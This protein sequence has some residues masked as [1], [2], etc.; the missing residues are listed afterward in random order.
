M[1]DL[2]QE[3]MFEYDK[4]VSLCNELQK[5]VNLSFELYKEGEVSWEEHHTLV[6][7]SREAS[8]KAVELMDNMF[9]IR[10]QQKIEKEK[11]ND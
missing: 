3:A 10:D 9:K 6:G 1:T 4:Q 7:V 2:L 8:N 5:E 11:T